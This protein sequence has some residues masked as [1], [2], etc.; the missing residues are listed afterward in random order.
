M[1]NLSTQLA[2]FGGGCFWCTEAVFQKLNGV[3]SVVSGYADGHI[4][5]PSY[6]QI[7]T[8]QSGHAEVFQIDFDPE[9]ISFAELLEIFFN[10]HD[11][12]T[13]NQQGADRGTQYRSTILCH[14]EEQMIQAK[15]YISELNQS[16]QW[17]NPIV[18][19]V[20]LLDVFYAAEDYHQDY[21][22]S[23]PD[24]GYCRVTI[25]PKIEKLY[26]KYPGLLKSA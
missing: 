19:D 3:N 11:P 22:Q 10:F 16:K 6:E 25:P 23:N 13:L 4:E 2:T 17:L 20:K 18:T 12:T 5:N 21:Y 14:N 15:N 7:C 1:N 9:L 26:K 24:S 8:G